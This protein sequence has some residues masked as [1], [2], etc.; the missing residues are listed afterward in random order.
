[1]SISTPLPLPKYPP[2]SDTDVKPI[3][4]IKTL[5]RRQILD[6]QENCEG[7]LYF[8]DISEQDLQNW[9]LQNPDLLEAKDI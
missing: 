9:K 3:F 8:P 4:Q 7:D 1:M 6:L 2:N 5:Q